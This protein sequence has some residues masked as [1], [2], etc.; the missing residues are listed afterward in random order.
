[1]SRTGA[2]QLRLRFATGDNNDHAADY[3]VFSSGNAAT[4]VRPRLSIVY[5]VP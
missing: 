1:V 2:T 3:L 5:Y 4:A